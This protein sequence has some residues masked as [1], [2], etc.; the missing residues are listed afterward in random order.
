MS[1]RVLIVVSSS[2]GSSCGIAQG[3][4]LFDL[5]AS[6]A[7]AVIATCINL[8]V[9]TGAARGSPDAEAALLASLND[10]RHGGRGAES[11]LL[12]ALPLEVPCAETALWALSGLT[13]GRHVVCTGLLERSGLG[14]AHVT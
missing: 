8:F 3:A 10:G 6:W 2:L 7:T 11:A 13:D 12:T 1:R 4:A 14:V 9:R 5:P